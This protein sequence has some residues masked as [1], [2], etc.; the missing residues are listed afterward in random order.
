MLRSST[1]FR[2]SNTNMLSWIFWRGPVVGQ[3]LL[4]DAA[5]DGAFAQVED[6][7]RR[8]DAAE[9]GG[10]HVGAAGELALE[11]IVQLLQ[12]VGLDAVEAGDAQHDVAAQALGK[13]GSTRAAWSGSRNDIT[14]AM[15][16][17]CSRRIRSATDRASIHFSC[18]SPLLL[19]PSRMRLI[20]HSPCRGRAP[21]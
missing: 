15:I 10:L 14:I 18:S 8:L 11:D 1:S 13:L 3:D 9:R 4:H 17:G 6:A 19:R 2:L 5:L 16:C 21:G 12:G 20:T 7:R